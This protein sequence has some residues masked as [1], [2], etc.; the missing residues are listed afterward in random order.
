M[1]Y[2]VKNPESFKILKEKMKTCSKGRKLWLRILRFSFLFK[3]TA[4]DELCDVLRECKLYDCMI[5]CLHDR[6]NYEEVVSVIRKVSRDHI[7]I[8][9]TNEHHHMEAVKKFF[10]ACSGMQIKL[11]SISF[12]GDWFLTYLEA[13]EMPEVEN[14]ELKTMSLS[15][16]EF[17]FC[18]KWILNKK[19]TCNLRFAACKIPFNLS[20]EAKSHIKSLRKSYLQVHRIDVIGTK[21]VERVALNFTTGNWKLDA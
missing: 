3:R 15:E 17:I 14:V 8:S 13:L 4:F 1:Y 21:E 11:K 9:H 2:I 18:L 10:Q 12:A 16:S 7:V 20:A 19:F 6:A 5:D